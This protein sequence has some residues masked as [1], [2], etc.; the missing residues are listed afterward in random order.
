MEPP[1]TPRPT[2]SPTPQPT[3]SPT[4]QPT[5]SPTP[6]PVP[7]KPSASHTSPSSAS[8]TSSGAPPM[9]PP[10]SSAMAQTGGEPTDE[11]PM[12]VAVAVSA[13]V[14]LFLAAGL[15]YRKFCL[16]D[17]PCKK[18]PLIVPV[19]LRRKPT[20]RS[21]TLAHS[22]RS[23]DNEIDASNES[24]RSRPEVLGSGNL[25]LPPGT[26]VPSPTALQ[27]STQH[28][29]MNE[30]R[31]RMLVHGR[32]SHDNGLVS[33]REE[34]KLGTVER[35]GGST[36]ARSPSTFGNTG[37]QVLYATRAVARAAQ[38]SSTPMV[39]EVRTVESSCVC[40]CVYLLNC[41]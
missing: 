2:M 40:V 6:I 29:S 7:P 38:S 36:S 1:P 15:A 10:M 31:P 23:G 3:M 22:S 13:V 35:R 37:N 21:P 25:P 28:P 18:L 5:M 32:G 8:P 33:G 26:V 39:P 27:P 4:T 30:N 19:P 41:T 17:G 12:I 14:G 16:V 11:A 20:A 34:T 9:P 24:G